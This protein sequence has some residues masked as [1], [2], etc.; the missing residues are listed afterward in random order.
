MRVLC[1]NLIESY[2]IKRFYT[3]VSVSI[4]SLSVNSLRTDV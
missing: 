2:K 3:A 1:E 4:N